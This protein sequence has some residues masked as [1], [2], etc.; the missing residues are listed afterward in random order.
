MRRLLYRNFRLLHR[1][2]RW[3]ARR[4]TP[5]G[6]VVAGGALGA[7]IFGLDTRQ[8][9]AHQIAALL[10]CLLLVALAAGGCQHAKQT[11]PGYEPSTVFSAMVGAAMSVSSVLPVNTLRVMRVSAV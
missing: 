1:L 4:F 7:A 5:L 10:A 9:L 3:L 11:F 6:S 2:G 8:T